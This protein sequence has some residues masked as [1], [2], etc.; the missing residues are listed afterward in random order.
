LLTLQKNKH[1]KSI[2]LLA[3]FV[4]LSKF[5][6]SQLISGTLVDDQR[7]MTSTFDFKIKGNYKGV[8]YFELAVNNEGVVTGI[9]EEMQDDSF[10][11]TPAKIIAQKQLQKLTFQKGTH[12]PKFHHV[13]VKVEFV[14]N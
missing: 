5:S 7:Q 13:L 10:V 14:L 11:S 3:S 4:I 2:L 12:F 6:F 9:K 1:M 8:K